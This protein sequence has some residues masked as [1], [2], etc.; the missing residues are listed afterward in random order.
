ML[1]EKW[2]GDID[3]VAIQIHFEP[4]GESLGLT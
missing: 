2:R 3:R 1:F 4:K